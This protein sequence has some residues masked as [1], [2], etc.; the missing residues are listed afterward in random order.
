MEELFKGTE[1]KYEVKRQTVCSGCRGTGAKN[2]AKT[3]CSE[4]MGRGMTTRMFGPGMMVQQTCHK[5]QGRGKVIHEHCPL[6]MGSKISI[7]SMQHRV[8]VDKGTKDG[9]EIVMN[10]LGDE[11][12][13][14]ESGNLVFKV[15]CANHND[16][17]RKSNNLFRFVFITLDEA[18]KGFVKKIPRLDGTN[19]E[20]ARNTKT[21][22][23]QTIR[24]PKEGL[25]EDGSL[26]IT[27]VVQI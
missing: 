16:Y 21:Q 10:G 18:K 8:F 14:H 26:Y 17:V 23:N 15:K 22:P 19:L 4:C 3:Q 11:M 20:I 7:N 6:C 9:H 24:I 5:C 13:E 12:P 25:T 1:I 27:F 2:G